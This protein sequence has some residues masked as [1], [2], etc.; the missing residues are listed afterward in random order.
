MDM[1]DILGYFQYE[2]INNM[3]MATGQGIILIGK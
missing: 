2:K 3:L 1:H